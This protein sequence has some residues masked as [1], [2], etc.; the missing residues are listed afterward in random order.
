MW[1]SVSQNGPVRAGYVFGPRN[2]VLT[3]PCSPS[4]HCSTC[5][6]QTGDSKRV[7]W[8][9]I[10]LLS[11]EATGTPEFR[12]QHRSRAIVEDIWSALLID[13]GQRAATTIDPALGPSLPT[14]AR[15]SS[16]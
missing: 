10:L 13:G 8:N 4:G 14:T 5:T 1:A 16:V 6:L 9:D 7:S 15:F 12:V 3:N 11:P 2:F